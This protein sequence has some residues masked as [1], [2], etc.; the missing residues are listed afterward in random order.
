MFSINVLLYGDYPDLA[1]RCLESIG[2][3]CVTSPSL[4]QDVRVGMNAVSQGVRRYAARWAD[5]IST[6][7]D[8]LPVFIYNSKHNVR[9]Y[10]LMRRMFH[11][12]EKPITAEWVMWFDDDSFFKGHVS[13]GLSTLQSLVDK[14]V[15]ADMYGSVWERKLHGNQKQFFESLHW[16]NGIPTNARRGGSWVSFV[17]GGWW[18]LRSS[19]ISLYDW[20]AKE[21][22]HNGG[23]MMLGALLN[24][25]RRKVVHVG[26][27][28]FCV[29]INADNGG[30]N[31]SMPRRG[32]SEGLVGC[33]YVKNKIVDLSYHDFEV[34]RVEYPGCKRILLSS[35]MNQ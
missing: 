34:H 19:V 29:A 15:L 22:K 12:L 28:D 35:E 21:I 24:Q 11:D 13:N 14:D 27:N 17:T 3:Q 8:G 33:G 16:W 4:V 5:N 18:L 26:Y 30:K 1:Q 7:C 20:P 23:D 32:L 9:K 2:K 10:P 31:S 6:A 25:Q